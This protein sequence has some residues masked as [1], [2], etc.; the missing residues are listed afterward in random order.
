MCHQVYS[1]AQV[2]DEGCFSSNSYDGKA[3]AVAVLVRGPLFDQTRAAPDVNNPSALGA[4]LA[5]V[6]QACEVP[7]GND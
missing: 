4:L 1:F 5:A 7:L 3:G 6:T 2:L